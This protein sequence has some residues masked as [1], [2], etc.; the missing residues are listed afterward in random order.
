MTLGYRNIVLFI[1]L[2]FQKVLRHLRGLAA[3]GLADNHHDLMAS[4]QP[5]QLGL[6][7]VEWQRAFV[8]T[9]LTLHECQHRDRVRVILN[10]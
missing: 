3:A 1:H 10:R 9:T 4:H 6:M 5:L 7:A 2:S 8:P